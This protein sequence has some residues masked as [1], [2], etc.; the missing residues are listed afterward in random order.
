MK[1]CVTVH[2]T[3][4]ADEQ[5]EVNAPARINKW[6]SKVVMLRDGGKC[7]LRDGVVARC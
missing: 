5:N 4:D 7:N 2:V 1:G 3:I 6:Y